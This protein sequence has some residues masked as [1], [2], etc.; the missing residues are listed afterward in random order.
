VSVHC[1][2]RGCPRGT[3]RKHTGK[4]KAGRLV[5]DKLRGSVRAGAKITVVSKRTGHITAFDTYIV[6][7]K[8]RSPLLREQCQWGARKKPRACP[9]S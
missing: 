4:K 5:F 6:R 1:A 8:K 2:G 3:F 7:G 9:S